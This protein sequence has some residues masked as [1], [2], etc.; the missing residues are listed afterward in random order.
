VLT[1]EQ[2]EQNARL[3]VVTARANRF[4]DSVALF[5]ALGGGWWNRDDVDPLVAKCC[6]VLP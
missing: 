3:N 2:T 5:Q 4:T 6:G 1:A